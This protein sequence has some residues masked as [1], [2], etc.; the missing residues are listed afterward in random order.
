MVGNGAT[1]WDFDSMPS[2][3]ETVWQFNVIPPSLYNDYRSNKCEVYFNGVYDGIVPPM[4]LKCQK[5]WH[6]MSTMTGNLNWYDLYRQT[7]DSPLML[8]SE[9]RYGSSIVG[10]EEK[11]YKRGMTMSEYTPW[12]K[13][14]LQETGEDIILGDYVSDYMNRADVRAALHI[15]ESAPA[16][17]M[18]SSTLDYNLQT[19]ASRW[20]Y[21]I[22]KGKAKM[23]FYSGDTDGAIPIYGSKEW[24][25][26]LDREVEAI[27]RPWYTHGQ[28]SGYI[29]QYD[30][31]DFV[32]VKG[33]GHMAP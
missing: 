20:I 17:E 8:K 3:P 16:W 25:K 19:E 22:L 12:A 32:T 24:I 18:C 21:D 10:G 4:S 11:I 7:Y 23:M 26:R 31:L 15:P 27:W 30:G 14:I 5:L 2:F 1:D 9:E 28:V 33:V 6:K 29:E 13:H